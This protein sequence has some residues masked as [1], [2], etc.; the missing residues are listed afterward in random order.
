MTREDQEYSEKRDF[1]RMFIEAPIEYCIKGSNDWKKGVGKDLSASG[2]AFTVDDPVNEGDLIEIKLKP[3]TDVTPPLEAT[4]K[5]IRSIANDSG[6]YDLSTIIEEI[7][8]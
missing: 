4:V 5:V 8:R 7:H 6:S 2:M 3:S 1:I